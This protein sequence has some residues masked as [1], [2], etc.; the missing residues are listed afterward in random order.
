MPPMAR[1]FVAVTVGVVVAILVVMTFDK[2]GAAIHP[3]PPGLDPR[4]TA[5]IEAHIASAPL[6]ALLA[7]AL[8]W[9]L[10]P[11]A[12]GL[13]ATKLAGEARP[14]YSWA[15]TLV[16]LSTTLVNLGTYAHPPLMWLAATVGIPAAGWLAARL[17]PSLV[18]RPQAAP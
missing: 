15:I 5:L 3:P 18:R 7:M 11:F 9:M 13:V 4:Q 2:L 14:M 12:G 10:A 6:S 8:G 16:F 1:S 17:S